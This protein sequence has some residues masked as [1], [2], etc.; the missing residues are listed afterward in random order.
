MAAR[1][2]QMGE[3]YARAMESAKRYVNG[4]RPDQWHGPTPCT[5]WDV[6]TLVNHIT[7]ENVWAGELFQGKT[8]AEVGDRF[9]G[10]LLGDDPIGAYSRSVEVARRAA[11]APGA[12]E[13]ST[14]LSSGETPGSEYASQLFLDQLVHGWDLAKATGQDTLLD[15]E[16]VEAGMPLAE[17]TASVAVGSGAFAPPVQ[18]AANADA[19]TRLLALLGRQP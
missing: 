6:R 19:Q 10:D 12:M 3:L 14:H 2:E 15:P 8:L 9:E 5:E 4:V 7:Y 1:P 11:L 13:V 16:L 18:V 17:Y